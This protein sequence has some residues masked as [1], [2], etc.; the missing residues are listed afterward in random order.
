MPSTIP[1]TSAAPFV[2]T[3]MKWRSIYSSNVTYHIR[4]GWSIW[5]GW[6]FRARFNPLSFQTWLLKASYWTVRKGGNWWFSLW[7][8]VVWMLRK[9]RNN[10]IFRDLKFS[11]IKTVDKIKARLWSWVSMKDPKWVNFSFNDWLLK[12][13]FVVNS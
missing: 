3:M 7:L 2:E 12:P 9:G 10:L 4:C 13:L 8:C 1:T 5:S 11:I 6:V